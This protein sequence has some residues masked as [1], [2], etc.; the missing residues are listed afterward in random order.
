L[1]GC[2][3]TRKF[4]EPL[5]GTF[6]L[7]ALSVCSER[8]GLHHVDFNSPGRERTPKASAEFVKKIIAQR[9]P[10]DQGGSASIASSQ[11]ALV[12]ALIMAVKLIVLH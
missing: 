2:E 6:T 11:L 9:L 8:F 3:D 7:I 12:V 5:V 4:C 10:K 1:S